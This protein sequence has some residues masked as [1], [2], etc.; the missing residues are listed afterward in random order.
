VMAV[1][2]LWMLCV[3]QEEVS[4]MGR[5]LVQRSLTKCVCVC[6]CVRMC[7]IECDQVQK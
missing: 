2:L 3:A 7:V 1:C 4:A 5:S 6:V